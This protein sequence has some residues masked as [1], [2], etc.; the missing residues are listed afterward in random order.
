MPSTSV[1][2]NCSTSEAPVMTTE[3]GGGDCEERVLDKDEWKNE[4]KA[5]IKDIQDHVGEMVISEQVPCTN[6]AVYCNLKTLEGK[7]YCVELTAAGFRYSSF[8]VFSI[9]CI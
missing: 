5:V 6:S 9:K 2:N 8:F 7:K 1:L 4:A 3:K